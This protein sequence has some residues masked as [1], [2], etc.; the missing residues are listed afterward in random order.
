MVTFSIPFTVIMTGFISYAFE[1]IGRKWTLS[2]SYF[3]TALIWI[4]MPHTAPNLTVLYVC[5]CAIGLTM[6]APLAHPLLPDWVE[7]TSRGR[8]LALMGI[9]ILFGNIYA[10]G[11]LF[12]FTKDM[13]FKNAFLIAGIN[14]MILSVVFLIIIKDPDFKSLRQNMD[15]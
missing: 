13:D 3:L 7:K 2:I 12:N 1:L 10:I 14:I 9:G 5:R 4:Y 15:I 6:A 11:V 8:G